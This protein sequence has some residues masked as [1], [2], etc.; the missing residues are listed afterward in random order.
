LLFED[1]FS[2]SNTATIGYQWGKKGVQPK[3]KSKQRGRQRKTAIGSFNPNYTLEKI[4]KC[5]VH[6]PMKVSHPFRFK[7]SHLGLLFW[8]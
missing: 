5:N 1:E 8:G 7:V 3:V 6:I 2:L 4:I